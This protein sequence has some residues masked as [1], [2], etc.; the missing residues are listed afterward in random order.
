MRIRAMTEQDV[1]AGVHLNTIAGWNQTAADWIRFLR[2]SPDACFVMEHQG[3]VIGTAATIPYGTR[4][5]WIGMV[6]VDPR[7]RG[8]GAG[9]L[10]LERAIEHLSRSHIPVMKLD[11]TPQ[12]KP[13]YKKLGFMEEYELERWVLKRLP[14]QL[15]SSRATLSELEWQRIL[16]IDRQVFGGDRSVLLRSLH[17]EFP[18]LTFTSLDGGSLVG[19]AFGRHGL[20]ADHFGPWVSE[21]PSKT[22][23]LLN[24]FLRH[25]PRETIVVDCPKD[26]KAVLDA[27]RE[28]GR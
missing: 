28:N 12:G 2:F 27:L 5:A 23:N 7:F 1:P 8:Q 14:N 25:S 11:A 4:F 15:P 19:Y 20:F 21:G 22:V 26:N 18:E 3:E 13:L 17:S 16:S 24:E 10:L 6:L 9:T